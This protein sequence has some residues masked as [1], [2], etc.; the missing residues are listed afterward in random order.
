MADDNPDPD[1]D[2]DDNDGSDDDGPAV[3]SKSSCPKKVLAPVNRS[4]GYYYP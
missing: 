4:A 1:D 2:D 3:S